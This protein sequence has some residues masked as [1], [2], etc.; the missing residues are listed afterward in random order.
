MIKELGVKA[1]S[2]VGGFFRE[3]V[4]GLLNRP[5]VVPDLKEKSKVDELGYI[6]FEPQNYKWLTLLHLYA[7]VYLKSGYERDMGMTK[8]YIQ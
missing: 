6:L 7:D 2:D 5:D 8:L 1:I 4:G 3:Q